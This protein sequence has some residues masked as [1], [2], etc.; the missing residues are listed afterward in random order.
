M[1][2]LLH[3]STAS[4]CAFVPENCSE[5]RR[6]FN[7][8]AVVSNKCVNKGAMSCAFLFGS[9]VH[10][11]FSPVIARTSVLRVEVRQRQTSDSI[12]TLNPVAFPL[13]VVLLNAIAH[14]TVRNA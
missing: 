2:G 7:R 9:T 5:E 14:H 12:V 11:P 6:A 10:P 8:K 1:V 3:Y 13:L 4:D